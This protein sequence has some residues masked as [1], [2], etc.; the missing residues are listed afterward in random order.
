[1]AFDG[2]RYIDVAGT[3]D[4]LAIYQDFEIA[5]STGTA[6]DFSL[7]VRSPDGGPRTGQLLLSTSETKSLAESWSFRGRRSP[8]LGQGGLA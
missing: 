3:D 2:E 7:W 6:V 8:S 4:C 5:V 1:M